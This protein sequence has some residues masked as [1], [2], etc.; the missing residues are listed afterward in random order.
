VG[1]GCE[2]ECVVMF[3]AS[4]FLSPVAPIRYLRTF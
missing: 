1:L 3:S 4:G 2:K